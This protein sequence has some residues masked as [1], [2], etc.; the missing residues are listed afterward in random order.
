MPGAAYN[1]VYEIAADQNG[2]FTTAQASGAAVEKG[3]VAKMAQRGVV[4][5][6]SWGVYRLVQFPDS[7]L[8]AYVEACLWPLSAP[9]VLSHES[10]L[11][12]Y[13]L[14]DVNPARIHIT[15]PMSFRVQRSLPAR[16]AIHRAD[17]TERDVRPYEGLTIT[18]P[19]RTIRDCHAAH[20]GPALVRQA[21]RDGRRSGLLRARQAD[22]LER[23]LLG[24]K[25][26][27]EG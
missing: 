20:L 17:L 2:Y 25:G 1:R 7:P 16:L 24:G 13:D 8:D 15:V 22:A 6:V 14:S 4:E 19:E 23:E 26:D 10:A 3:T 5:R 9:A 21:I 12:V 27:G 18:T 11:A